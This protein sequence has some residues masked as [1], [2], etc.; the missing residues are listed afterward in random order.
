M[1]TKQIKKRL[2]THSKIKYGRK[3]INPQS[4]N[5]RVSIENYMNGGTSIRDK[6]C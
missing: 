4:M 1:T 2:R 5:Q 6:L 3:C